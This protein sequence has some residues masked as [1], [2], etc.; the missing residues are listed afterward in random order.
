MN[1]N[2]K[3]EMSNVVPINCPQ[4]ATIHDDLNGNSEH[5]MTNP[6]IKKFVSRMPLALCTDV[7]A[8]VRVIRMIIDNTKIKKIRNLTL[9]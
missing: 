2:D 3:A 7:E 9:F 8:C 6:Y 1:A 5:I 4:N